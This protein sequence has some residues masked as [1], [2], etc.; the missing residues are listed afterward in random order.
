GVDRR[1]PEVPRR[2][3]A[4]DDTAH[5]RRDDLAH[6]A[7]SGFAD[8]CRQCAAKLFGLLRVHEH[9]GLLQEDRRAQAA[10]EDEVAVEQRARLAEQVQDFVGGHASSL[11]RS[12]GACHSICDSV[13]ASPTVARCTSDSPEV[14][15]RVEISS[16]SCA[17]SRTSISMTNLWK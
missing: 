16:V 9:A 1:H 10:A 3:V 2:L 4:G 13:M 5:S 12:A 11:S 6:V 7:V 14:S 8:L 15:L 17:R